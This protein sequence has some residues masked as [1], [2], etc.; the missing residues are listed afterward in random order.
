MTEP[1]TTPLRSERRRHGV[2]TSTYCRYLLSTMFGHVLG[3]PE[4]TGDGAPW[5]PTPAPPSEPRHSS[6][7]FVL[8]GQRRDAPSSTARSL[9]GSAPSTTPGSPSRS[10]TG[11][12]TTS[13]S[14][15]SSPRAAHFTSMT[16]YSDGHA[17]RRGRAPTSCCAPPPSRSRR[18]AAPRHP[19]LNLHG[20]GLDTAGCPVAP[21][22]RSPP[23]MWDTARRTLTRI[24]EL[25]EREGVDVRAREP[26]HGRRPPRHAVRPGC[27]HPRPRARHRLT[28]PAAQP[29]P[30]PRADRR[31]EPHRALP[32]GAAV[33]RRDPGGRR[34][35]PLRAGHR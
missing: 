12:T 9:T 34:A 30:L 14:S 29:R 25:G 19:S 31:G 21:P 32:R 1:V 26:Q 13:T 28:P 2:H 22:T 20:T 16:G 6:T 17:R 7:P 18:V 10:G 15:R 4:R 3:S 23:A 5:R 35:R 24:A 33:D 11:A 27:R 8:G